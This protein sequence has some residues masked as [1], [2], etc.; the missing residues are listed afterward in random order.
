[1]IDLP[2]SSSSSDTDGPAGRRPGGASRWIGPLLA[3]GTLVVMFVAVEVGLRGVLDAELQAMLPHFGMAEDL[4]SRLAWVDWQEQRDKYGTTSYPS[5]FDRP[6]AE[7]GWRIQPNVAV[8]H[9]KPGAYEV[10]VHTNNAGM[11]GTEPVSRTKAASTTRIGVFGC[12]QTFGETVNDDETYVA[13]LADTL[14]DAELLNFGVRGYGTDQ[15][16]LYH[17]Q[18]AAGYD[19]DVVVLA[20]A[21]YHM[22]RNATG[23]LF[24][25]KPY[26]ELTGDELVLAGVPVP[27]PEQ[28]KSEDFSRYTWK[29]ADHSVA[30]RWFWAKARSLRTRGL[31]SENGPAWQLSR[32]LIG[33]FVESAR[34]DG[35][36]VV[37]MNIDESRPELEGDLA[38][39]AEELSVGLVDLGPT[40]RAAGV[41]GVNYTLPADNHW[42]PTGHELVAAELA[43]HLCATGLVA[44]CDR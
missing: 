32:A 40:L 4:Q 5:S 20:F 42:N 6:D 8:T 19:L 13:R 18:E 30:L 27:T 12:S 11:R 29:L 43:R 1:M 10:A 22:K 24:Y 25:A 33:R 17:Q 2:S 38:G 16:L 39:L 14:P 15:M 35:S 3:L 21:F 7:L 23:F 34:A 9:V 26:F 31:Y 37:L 44:D 28:L 36:H 41:D